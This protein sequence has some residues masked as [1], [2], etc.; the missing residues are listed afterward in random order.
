M[1]DNLSD[2]R[3]DLGL[4]KKDVASINGIFN[5]LDDT[6]DKLQE[7]TMTMTRM[8]SVHEHRLELQEKADDDLNKLIELRRT[9]LQIGRAHV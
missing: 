2:M 6:I 8:I 7:L 3:L 5:K 4:L 9:E 1:A